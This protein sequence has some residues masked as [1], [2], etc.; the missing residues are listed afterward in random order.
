MAESVVGAPPA[1]I[2]NP[3]SSVRRLLASIHSG[4]QKSPRPTAKPKRPDAMN[5]IP[6]FR[7]TVPALCLKAP[8]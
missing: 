6:R 4:K 8:S 7:V 5:R 3:I 1:A 2:T